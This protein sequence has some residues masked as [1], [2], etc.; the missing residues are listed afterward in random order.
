MRRLGPDP[1][2]VDWFRV[3]ADLRYAGIDTKSVARMICV[4][5]ATVFGWKQGAEP[6]YADGERLIEFWL[7]V[8]GRPVATLPRAG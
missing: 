7:Q 4:P 8:L 5:A 3:L 6:K 2:R 1:R